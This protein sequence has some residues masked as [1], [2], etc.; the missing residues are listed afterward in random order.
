[1]RSRRI[2]ALLLAAAGIS[3][4]T[5]SAWAY[6]SQTHI[7][8]NE[9]HLGKYGTGIVEVFTPPKDWMPGQRV[10]KN[11]S[12]ENSGTVPVFVK[13]VLSQEWVRREN[14]YGPDGSA[15][16]PL[17]G[18]SF[19]LRFTTA[20]GGEAYAA[21]IGW[22]P[23]VVV[24]GTSP[25]LGLPTVSSMEQAR[26]KWLLTSETPDAQG[27]YTA[28]YIGVLEDG[29][30]TPL[31]V[32][33]VR[34][35]PDIQADILSERTVWDKA[36]KEW[37][38][39]RVRNPAHSYENARFTLGVTMYTVQATTDALLEIFPAGGTGEQAVI[40]GLVT[41]AGTAA[42]SRFPDG[43]LKKLYFEEA[44]GY[45]R[46]TPVMDGE[47]WFMSHLNM[48]PGDTY[49]DTMQ[50]ENR[51]AKSYDLYMQ[52]VPRDQQPLPQ[53][54]LELIHMKVWQGSN[55]IYDGT[56]LGKSYPGSVN[57]LHNVIALGKYLP[58]KEDS[59]RVELTLDK[60]TPIRYAG[61]LSL[62][63]W[64]FMVEDIPEEP[65]LTFVPP[66]T[67]DGSDLTLW[68]ALAGASLLGLAAVVFIPAWRRGRRE[69][70]RA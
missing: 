40:A 55:L 58:G 41:L 67:N 10:T 42:D 44:G 20:S 60:D 32:D 56:A 21:Q 6:W 35:H 62:I 1:M 15:I 22:G 29:K 50:I 2:L 64:K 26:G 70:S 51:S 69:E 28:Y 12:I 54:L 45:M 68:L 30:T 13:V 61:V 3:A 49:K 9:F 47:S 16:P 53:E 43:T 25:V 18:Q 65:P 33:N 4:M 5:G 63:D 17:Q 59:L 7:V 11:V 57:D 39:T 36:K 52:V 34:M 24:L 38:T 48:M 66:Q 8:A 46:Y 37:V 23:D 19:P 27:N 31:L 14:V